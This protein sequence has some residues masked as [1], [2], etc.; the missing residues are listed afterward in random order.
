MKKE[1][2]AFISSDGLSRMFRKP[3][4]KFAT[5]GLRALIGFL[6]TTA[7]GLENPAMRLMMIPVIAAYALSALMLRWIKEELGDERYQEIFEPR[8]LLGLKDISGR[9]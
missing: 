5:W 9:S 7:A 6:I 8:V 1:I 2:I 3:V 4:E